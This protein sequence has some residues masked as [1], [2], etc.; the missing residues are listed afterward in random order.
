MSILLAVKQE[1]LGLADSPL[2]QKLAR[3]FGPKMSKFLS[4]AQNFLVKIR[5]LSRKNKILLATT[6]VFTSA[7]YASLPWILEKIKAPEIIYSFPGNGATDVPVDSKI[8][9]TFNKKVAKVVA[10][11]SL[12]INPAVKGAFSWDN[13]YT[14]VFTPEKK[15]AKGSTYSYSFTL[16][17]PQ[18]LGLPFTDRTASVFETVGGL[19]VL[20]YAPA[21]T[22]QD[23]KAPIV[24]V[25][26]RPMI[27]ISTYDE[28]ISA[29]APIE[30][31]PTIG[32]KGEW[33]GSSA[34]KF[35]PNE[36]YN[37]STLY[38]VKLKTD[39]TALDGETI[40]TSYD[41]SFASN[42]PE[43]TSATPASG[44]KNVALNTPISLTFN[45][46]IDI[47]SLK[48]SLTLTDSN[49][50]THSY[51]ILQDYKTK[52]T[53]LVYISGGFKKATTYY[54]DLK[55]GLKPQN[56][57]LASILARNWSFTTVADPIVTQTYPE[58]GSESAP[59][60]YSSTVY[61]NGK[62][63]LASI[64]A[65][66]TITP[67]PEN[68][69]IHDCGEYCDDE[70]YYITLTGN[71][72]AETRYTVHIP[73]AVKS[74]HGYNM[75]SDYKYSF[76]TAPIR[77]SMG[78]KS[79]DTY[80][81][82]Y[83]YNLD[84]RVA[85]STINVSRLHY[86]LS[87][88][89]I[90]EFSNLYRLK[91]DY[92]YARSVCGNRE[93]Y[94]CMSW[95]KYT[96]IGEKIIEWETNLN[97]KK[98]ER[99]LTVQK[100]TAQNGAPLPPGLYFLQIEAPDEKLKDNAVVM[101]TDSVA[102]LKENGVQSFVWVVDQKTASPQQNRTVKIYKADGTLLSEGK[103]NSDGV[104]QANTNHGGYGIFATVEDENGFSLVTSNFDIGISKYD[105]GIYGGYRADDDNFKLYG[106]TDLPLYRTGE[107]ILFK[108]I[109][110]NA[111]GNSY[112]SV[113]GKTVTVTITN[114]Q[115]AKVYSEDFTTDENGAF[116]GQY[117]TAAQIPSGYYTL[118]LSYLNKYYYR[119]D[120][121]IEEYRKPEFYLDISPNKESYTRGQPNFVTINTSY[122]FGAP[123]AGK[124]VKYTVKVK[125]STFTWNKNH[126]FDFAELEYINYYWNMY[127][128]ADKYQ[129]GKVLQEGTKTTDADGNLRI[130]LP[131]AL[132]KSSTQKLVVEAMVEDLNNQAVAAS[133][134]I[135][136]HPANYYI[137]LKP[138]N[139]V[140]STKDDVR[141]EV[142]TVGHDGV[143]VGEKKIEAKIYRRTWNT[144]KEKDPDTGNYFY[145]S[146]PSDKL[147]KEKSLVTDKNGYGV[148]SFEP[149]EGGIYRIVA[150]ST[151]SLGN[152]VSSSTSVWVS[153]EG[154]E[155][156]RA[157]NDRINIITDKAEYQVGE[158]AKVF[159][160]SPYKYATKSLVTIERDGVLSYFLTETGGE[161]KAF[162]IQIT[163]DLFPNSYISVMAPKAGL[164][165]ES[166][167]EFKLGYAPIKVK[168][169]SRQLEV[170][171]RTDKGKYAP[172][173]KV[174]L[175]VVT[176]TKSGSP[177]SADLSLAVTDQAIWD[178]SGK[179]PTNIFDYY[180][181][182]KPLTV[183][184]SHMLTVSVDR[185]NLA[186]D[187][188]SK[189][190]GGGQNNEFFE[191]TRTKFL[192][193]AY[194]LP[195][196]KTNSSGYAKVEF[197]LPDNLTTWKIEGKAHSSAGQFGQGESKTLTTKDYVLR[198]FVSRFFSTGDEVK[199]GAIFVNN[200]NETKEFTLLLEGDGLELKSNSAI[201]QTLKPKEQK[202]FLVDSLITSTE[203]V[204]LKSTAKYGGQI[205]DSVE[206]EIPVK[207]HYAKQA[208]S[209]FGEIKSSTIEK[210]NIPDTV[211]P[212][213]GQIDVAVFP[214]PLLQ[215]L[216]SYGYM[217]S[218]PYECTEQISSRLL[219]TLSLYKIQKSYS[220][221]TIF[222]YSQ[223]LLADR[224]YRE[225]QTLTARQLYDGGWTWWEANTRQQDIKS[226]PLLSAY[227]YD[228]LSQ[229][230]ALGFTIPDGALANAKEYL[231]RQ[232]NSVDK[233]YNLLSYLLYSVG[234]DYTNNHAIE[235]LL[236]NR[237]AMN[238]EAKA[239]LA[240]YLYRLGGQYAKQANTLK[241][242]LL[243]LA[244][245]SDTLVN[246]EEPSKIYDFY[247]SDVSTT[248]SV[249]D[250]LSKY[251]P[252]HPYIDKALLYLSQKKQNDNFWIST[253]TTA[254]VLEVASTRLS[255]RGN[256]N[257]KNKFKVFLDTLEVLSG[258]YTND[259][260]F[261]TVSKSIPVKELKQNVHT[262]IKFE[263][264]GT[265]AL[266]YQILYKYFLRDRR[267]KPTE[268]GLSL[269]REFFDDSGKPVDLSKLKEKDMFWVKLTLVVP[270]TR[271][272]VLIEDYLPAG[273]ESINMNLAGSKILA[274]S[275]PKDL[276][277]Q[278]TDYWWYGN[279]ARTEYRDDVTAFFAGT[280]YPGVYEYSYKVRA[281]TP[282]IYIYPP[283]SA[284][285]MY[286]PNIFG[287][288]SGLEVRIAEH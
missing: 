238:M 102:A 34:Y 31:T 29:E 263:K 26:D 96:P 100:L 108:G 234:K 40:L 17:I 22:A 229:A 76:T 157:N 25:F 78:I 43:L 268:N 261:Q 140:Y 92:D 221:E 98:N 172:R 137:G 77:P 253:K 248:A 244:K 235:T 139:Y 19:K 274:G 46:P 68:F 236:T 223:K 111:D 122:Y 104:F 279:Y 201:T 8:Q 176:K 163:K 280:L 28:E 116:S 72:T 152:Q 149:E 214:S 270:S 283:A 165:A 287:N 246:W 155:T 113:A 62:M 208:S 168:D 109:L 200:S 15:L 107:T 186:I 24:V 197:E 161:S 64:K 227:A 103:T 264:S 74:A 35:T 269:V 159:A 16:P 88:L 193:T 95:Q 230:K 130:Q 212:D 87:K 117:A 44:G 249:I 215:S 231:I 255:N 173:D 217:S 156:L 90:Q 141:I 120:F 178:M 53:Y 127:N 251:D 125:D 83:D 129:S 7:L 11:K 162:D 267:Y 209:S 225:I 175:E 61:F 194:W 192:N 89:S 245:T 257:Y 177:V 80:F 196:V 5:G 282:G 204:N 218:Y 42:Y 38:T 180:Y 135:T 9:I 59:D 132:A 33:L 70:N 153:G 213:L 112:L 37:D 81:L 256:A 110:K 219:S 170:I 4:V 82:A 260:L 39:L 106:Y 190:G 115:G 63:D 60:L 276:T 54:V 134:E 188:G 48:E 166:P 179:N 143:E 183:N 169:D 199:I 258:E 131:A 56:G 247:G 250:L 67:K 32:G 198:P 207:N 23:G 73:R 66:L 160:D 252:G 220:I 65:G 154:Y 195:S 21:E 47:N 94:N 69:S 243:A 288:S 57:E 105:F 205:L 148:L 124:E 147:L 136:V 285:E 187:K 151:D 265:G 146:K 275:R 138:K 242:E 240:D 241:N 211:V 222:T 210:L 224:I 144:I 71:F 174:T 182:N 278:N 167:A 189:G 142:V 233:N 266:Y 284:Y 13:D 226:D 101:I 123:M 6:L 79:T 121:Q 10:E 18:Q 164:S 14:M 20:S 50:Q 277:Q 254:K 36:A 2:G 30:V 232:Q 118:A 27:D 93:Y 150:K 128:P 181:N 262:D 203:S 272:D 1:V 41:W 49:S 286:N 206:V 58:D 119:Y 133:K 126:Y 239:Y 99:A 75:Q 114:S 259:N 45:Q 202:K 86:S 158:T 12:Q 3:L 85:I 228:V 51:T 91:Y 216:S 84:P 281:T 52:N 185:V 191:T 171:I 184:T 55:T 273:V 237:R 97:Q 271:N 145:S